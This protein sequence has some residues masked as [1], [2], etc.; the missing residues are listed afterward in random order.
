VSGEGG[1]DLNSLVSGGDG[2]GDAGGELYFGTLGVG[3]G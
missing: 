2:S 1:G 3:G